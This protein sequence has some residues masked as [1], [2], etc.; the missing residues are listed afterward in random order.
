MKQLSGSQEI[1]E[2]IKKVAIRKKGQK[3]PQNSSP[4]Q[5]D[6]CGNN[7]MH[8]DQQDSTFQKF[9]EIF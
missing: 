4:G 6:R 2:H 7:F 1:K 9:L 5:S 8:L 3:I